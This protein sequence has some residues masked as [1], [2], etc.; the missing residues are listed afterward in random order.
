MYFDSFSSK[1]QERAGP[2]L[3][4]LIAASVGET[5]KP[6]DSVRI[7]TDAA[8]ALFPGAEVSVENVNTDVKRDGRHRQNGAI[9]AGG[10]AGPEGYTLASERRIQTR[11][12]KDCLS[13]VRAA[14]GIN[15]HWL[16]A[17]LS[18]PRRLEAGVQAS[19]NHHHRRR[20]MRNAA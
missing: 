13:R 7:V 4:A 20:M 11:F 1:K 5:S 12:A 15:C 16:W 14:I 3:A 2:L 8:A 10:L 17:R 19:H 6:W 9:S 18:V